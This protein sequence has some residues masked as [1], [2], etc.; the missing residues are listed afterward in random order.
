[1]KL[2]ILFL[3]FTFNCYGQ[4]LSEEDKQQHFA[5]GAVFS[6]PVYSQV[7]LETKDLGKSIGYGLLAST[8][9][10]ISKEVVDDKF[11]KRDLIATML[12]SIAS[13]VVLTIIM[14]FN[15]I[16]WQKSQKNNLRK[17]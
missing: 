16:K 6:S 4:L 3:L 12:G 15:K 7:Y 1:V 9:V 11:D 8:F 5:A 13:S 17:L 10:G 2:K 14:K